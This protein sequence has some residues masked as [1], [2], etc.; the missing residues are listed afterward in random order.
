MEPHKSTSRTVI[1]R[2]A[3]R[4]SMLILT[5]AITAGCGGSTPPGPGPG[6]GTGPTPPQCAQIRGDWTASWQMTLCAGEPKGVSTV[7]VE[8]TGCA[9]KFDVPNF[10]AFSGTLV[11]D[12]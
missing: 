2:I 11:G 4:P 1:A 9:I 3:A 5:A 8:Q 12:Q 6:P 10:G 7:P